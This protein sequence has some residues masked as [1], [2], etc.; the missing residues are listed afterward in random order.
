MHKYCVGDKK[1]STS[2]DNA[3]VADEDVRINKYYVDMIKKMNK[4]KKVAR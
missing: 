3:I 4:R 2:I 1:M